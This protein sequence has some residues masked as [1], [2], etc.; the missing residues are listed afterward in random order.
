MDEGTLE[1]FREILNAY[2]TQV[3]RA[4]VLALSNLD[5]KGDNK[6]SMDEVDATANR[7]VGR[8]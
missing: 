4:I 1:Y 8:P 5:E 2:L 7:S 6:D 3:E